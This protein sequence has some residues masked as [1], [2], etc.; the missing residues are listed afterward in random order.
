VKKVLLIVP[1]QLDRNPSQRF[2]IEQYINFLEKQGYSFQVSYLLNSKDDKLFYA[3][4][5]I[6]NK[7]VLLLKFI[8]FRIKDLLQ[9]NKFDIIFVQRE[10]IF[11]GTSLFEFIFSKSSAFF[12]YD[13]DDSIWL[14]NVSDVNKSF[15]WLKKYNKTS[16]I[17][18]YADLTIT[19]NEYLA[20][21]AKQ[22]SPNVHIIPTTVDTDKFNKTLVTE[23]SYISIGWSGSH[24]TI[25]Y[26]ESIID[27]LHKISL[28]YENKVKFKVISN[29]SCYSNKINI[30]NVIWSSEKEVEQLS[31]ID[32]GIMPLPD[33]EWTKGKCGLKG[34]VFMSLQIPVIMSPVGVNSSIIEDNINGLL[35]ANNDEWFK[36]L[37]LL[38]ENPELRVRLGREGRKTVVEKYSIENNKLKYLQLFQKR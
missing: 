1:H 31:D 10:A 7:F 21:Y 6:F 20:Q 2:R 33:N 8:F 28:K 27:V 35:A 3:K 23:K 38:I 30:D 15:D 36:K 26:F 5:F 16:K 25:K 18:K 14:P 19:G 4:G 17:I 9:M 12:I 13:F 37:C 11:I 34:L 22:F 24:T 29:T 32:I